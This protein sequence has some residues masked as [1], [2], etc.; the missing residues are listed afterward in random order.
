MVVIEAINIFEK[1]KVSLNSLLKKPRMSN[2]KKQQLK[3]A[4]DEIDI[5]IKTLRHMH[6]EQESCLNSID[7]SSNF[8]RLISRIRK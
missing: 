4:I 8:Q 1:R 7:D 6:L 3:G 5:F 2:N